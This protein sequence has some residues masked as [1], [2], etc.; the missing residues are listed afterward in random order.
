MKEALVIILI[1]ILLCA[2]IAI[3]VCLGGYNNDD[4]ED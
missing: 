3:G 1:G 4:N 2:F